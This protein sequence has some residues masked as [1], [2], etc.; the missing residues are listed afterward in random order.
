MSFVLNKRFIDVIVF[1]QFIRI[2]I[3]I[4][5]LHLQHLNI[6]NYFKLRKCEIQKAFNQFPV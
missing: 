5:F 3:L 1:F 6:K 4:I 2:R